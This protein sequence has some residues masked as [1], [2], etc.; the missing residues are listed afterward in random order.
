[1]NQPTRPRSRIQEKNRQAILAAVGRDRLVVTLE[2]HTVVGGLAESV[3][4]GGESWVSELSDDE[5]AALVELGQA[6]EVDL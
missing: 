2:N 5:L 6:G 4:G 1:M 3:V